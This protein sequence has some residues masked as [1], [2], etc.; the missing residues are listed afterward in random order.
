MPAAPLNLVSGSTMVETPLNL[1]PVGAS[2]RTTALPSI[3]TGRRIG[4]TKWSS[5]LRNDMKALLYCCIA[6]F[7]FCPALPAQVQSSTAIA[8]GS[9]DG[10]GIF[11][12]VQYGAVSDGDTDCTKAIQSAIDAASQK[13]GVVLVPVGRWACKGNLEIKSGVHVLGLNQA[14][15]SWEPAT[16]SILLPTAGRDN[17]SAPAFIEMRSS[18]S[19][20]G[21][22]IY[23]PDQKADDIR[24][25][26][27]T[28]QIRPN[29]TATNEVSFDSTVENVTLINSYNVIRTG[30]TENG[31]H[32]LLQINGCV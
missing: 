6:G 7:M 14:P 5:G 8:A 25:Y 31:R 1:Q 18:T 28:I 9:G 11:N 13:G 4:P 27:W 15:Q 26:P 19:L 32:R 12:I 23:Y 16:G 3:T 22:T 20:K 17:E 21:L 2:P 30:P 29:P 24:P 10:P